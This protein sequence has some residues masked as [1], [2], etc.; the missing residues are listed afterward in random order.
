MENKERNKKVKSIL[1]KHFTKVSVTGGKG[2]AHGW[3]HISVIADDPCPFRQH[4]QPCSY[5]FKCQDGIC[6]GNN[7]PVSAGWAGSIR[8]KT[9]RIIDD[10]INSLIKDIPFYNYY[11]DD[12]YNTKRQE[13]NIDIKFV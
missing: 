12:G 9:W 3:C 2:T 7:M 4:E 1:S 8:Q 11:A 10:T 5:Y 13:V 6:K